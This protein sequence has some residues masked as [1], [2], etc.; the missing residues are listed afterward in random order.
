M[1]LTFEVE[2]TTDVLDLCHVLA[3]AAHYNRTQADR[4]ITKF[5]EK[6]DAV[7]ISLLRTADMYDRIVKSLARQ[8]KAAAD[9]AQGGHK[10]SAP[11]S[12]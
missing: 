11:E 6:G 8:M 12:S 1:K 5:G 9:T 3:N 10:P 4:W 7:D 2:R